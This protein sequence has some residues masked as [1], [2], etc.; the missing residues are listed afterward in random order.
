MPRRNGE[1]GELVFTTLTRSGMPLIRYRTGDISRV[2]PEPCPCGS[3]LRRFER[4]S[5]RLSDVVRLAGGYTL[6]LPMLDEILFSLPGLVGFSAEILRGVESET[7]EL[8]VFARGGVVSA[9]EIQERLRNLAE[10][11]PP[12][13][14]C[15]SLASIGEALKSGRINLK[16]RHG[17][18]EVLTYG[19]TKRRIV[20]RL[21]DC[22][23]F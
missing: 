12:S 23:G 8:S 14:P 7:I 20:Y 10:T 11:L 17:G 13:N 2:I 15:Y 21:G 3:F 22:D 1:L 9:R 4:V 19:N 16:L 5:G 18:A 6:S